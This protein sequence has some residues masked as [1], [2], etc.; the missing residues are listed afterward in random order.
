MRYMN[1]LDPN[2]HK[3]KGETMRQ[4]EKFK[5]SEYDFKQKLLF[6]K[7]CNSDTKVMFLKERGFI[8]F[9]ERYQRIFG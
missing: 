3:P 9:G 8:A 5:H 2:S 7:R 1:L 4:S 6:L